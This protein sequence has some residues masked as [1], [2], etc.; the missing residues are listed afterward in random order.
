MKQAKYAPHIFDLS[1]GDLIFSAGT[2]EYN[3]YIST[4]PTPEKA[5][6][7]IYASQDGGETWTKLKGEIIV[8]S[9]EAT[10]HM[11]GLDFDAPY[12]EIT[13]TLDGV[14]TTSDMMFTNLGDV[15]I[16]VKGAV[17]T[18]T[19]VSG[20]NHGV[21]VHGAEGEQTNTLTVNSPKGYGVITSTDICIENLDALYVNTGLDGIEGRITIQNVSGAITAGE[22]CAAMKS[23]NP[24]ASIVVNGN[25]IVGGIGSIFR[26][27]GNVQKS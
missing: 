6:A 11:I 24:N 14:N 12:G 20:L 26:F 21:H 18:G 5:P 8:V 15:T 27:E 22:D 23:D 7:P 17:T 16:F 1:Q 10:D 19:I 3:A 13:L 4:D 2:E 25:E 9:S